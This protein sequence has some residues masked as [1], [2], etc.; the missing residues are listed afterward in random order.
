MKNTDGSFFL[1]RGKER[2]I[3]RKKIGKRRKKEGIRRRKKI[4]EY[5]IL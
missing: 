4:K 3:E 2:D 1:N 5:I